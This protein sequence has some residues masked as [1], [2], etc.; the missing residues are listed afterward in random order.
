MHTVE[1][2]YLQIY[3]ERCYDLLAL[4]AGGGGGG[5]D[6]GGGGRWGSDFETSGGGGGGGGGFL[7]VREHPETGPFVDGLS[8]HAVDGYAAVERLL[9]EGN[10]SRVIASTAMNAVSSRS[11]AIF[12]LRY[13]CTSA[14]EGLASELRSKV[15]LIDLAGSERVSKTAAAG[16]RLKEAGAIN[17]SLAT[18]G[19]VIAALAARATAAAGGGAPSAASGSGSSSASHVP[20]RDS[21]LTWLLRDSLGGNSRTLMIATISPSV[22]QLDETLSTLR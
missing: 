8:W 11:H 12:T 9:L 1:A 17:K 19:T 10:L 2:S 6:G 14:S 18:L 20:Y 21:V 7:R 4:Q 5:G 16:Q 15:S 3:M 22:L 13:T